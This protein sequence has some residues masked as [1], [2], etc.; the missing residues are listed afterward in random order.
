MLVKTISKSRI[1]KTNYKFDIG[2]PEPMIWYKKG[3]I[4][5]E[6]DL[7]A[8]VFGNG[9][10]YW[11]KDGGIHRDNNKPAIIYESGLKEIWENGNFIRLIINNK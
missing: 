5:R 9:T 2:S 1:D 3:D 11:Y 8:I 4:H 10:K 7:P 6:K